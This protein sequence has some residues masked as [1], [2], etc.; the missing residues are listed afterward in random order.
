M[1]KSTLR[2][3]LIGTALLCSALNLSTAAYSEAETKS[4]KVEVPVDPVLP[5]DSLAEKALDLTQA[6]APA[7]QNKTVVAQTKVAQI[8]K[9]VQKTP[10]KTTK[11]VAKPQ[12]AK[13]APAQYRTGGSFILKATA[14]NSFAG[15]TDSTPHIT[16]TGARTRFGIVALSRDMLRK[17]PYGSKVKIELLGKGASYY[18]RLLSQTVFVVEDTMHPRKYGQVDIWMRSMSEARSWGVRQVRLT[19]L[20]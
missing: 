10:Q 7:V 18:N 15:Q 8:A 16:A 4:L 5:A 2:F 9:T 3:T 17:I 13:V 6:T 1:A 14:Y 11:T 20:R 19:V 12:T